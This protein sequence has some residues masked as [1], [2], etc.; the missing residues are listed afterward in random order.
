MACG[1]RKQAA[2]TLLELMLVGLLL[3]LTATAVLLSVNLAGSDKRLEE[4]AYKFMGLGEMA[5]DEAV[6]SGRDLGIVF[7]KDSYQFVEL[8]ER[9]WRPIEDP[10]FK[11]QQLEGHV[12]DVEVEG[13]PWFADESDFS[14]DSLFEDDGLFEERD[15]KEVVLTPQVLL[16]SSG[17]IT[18]F[19]LNLSLEEQTDDKLITVVANGLGSFSLELA[20]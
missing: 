9:K 1:L 5:L 7:D 8:M 3:G 16:L 18:A 17:E 19:K 10:L 12:L 2:F 4:T 6:L 20:Q 14:S 11:K 15:E 13:F